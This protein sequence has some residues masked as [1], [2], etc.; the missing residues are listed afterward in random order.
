[1][2][3]SYYDYR[4]H[5]ISYREDGAEYYPIFDNDLMGLLQGFC[6]IEAMTFPDDVMQAIKDALNDPDEKHGFSGNIY[7]MEIIHGMATFGNDIDKEDRQPLV[8]VEIHD[9]LTL[10]EQWLADVKFLKIQMKQLPEKLPLITA[11]LKKEYSYTDKKAADAVEYLMQA[12][13]IAVEF[14]Y[15][16]EHGKFISEKYASIFYGYTAKQLYQ[17]TF[18]SLLGAFNYMIYLK[19]KP[20]EA[21]SNLRKGLPHDEVITSEREKEWQK[22]IK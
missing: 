3:K 18:L 4:I 1:M 19:K 22:H 10:M 7:Y 17:E 8:H 12:R 9:L 5:T 21:L 13:E 15:Y 11:Y 20:L 2:S 16:I 6:S 14:V